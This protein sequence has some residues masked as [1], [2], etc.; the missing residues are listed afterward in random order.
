MIIHLHFS[1]TAYKNCTQSTEC[2]VSNPLKQPNLN[3]LDFV[4]GNRL[5]FCTALAGEGKLG[6]VFPSMNFMRPL[7]YAKLYTLRDF[8][9]STFDLLML[10]P[11]S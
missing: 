2:C 11:N 9:T 6:L 3:F 1:S 7:S 4:I 5:S 8:V 10:E